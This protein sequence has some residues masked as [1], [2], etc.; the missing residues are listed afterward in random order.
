MINLFWRIKRGDKK[1]KDQLTGRKRKKGHGV[2]EFK[3]RRGEFLWV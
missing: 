2:L 1:K 3:N